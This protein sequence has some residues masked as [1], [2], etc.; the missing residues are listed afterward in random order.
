MYEGI[1]KLFKIDD[2]STQGT[3]QILYNIFTLI[4]AKI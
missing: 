1:K 2:I 4:F 3:F